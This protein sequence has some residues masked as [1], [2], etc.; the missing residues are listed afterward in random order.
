M[1]ITEMALLRRIRRRVPRVTGS[2]LLAG[3]GDDCA[4]FRAP[5]GE[6]LLYTTDLLI[7]RVHFRRESLPARLV[8][9][10]ALARGLSDVAAMGGQP[11][12][13][14]VSLALPMWADTRWVDSFYRGLAALAKETKTAVAGGDLSSAEQF[15][16]DIVV[17][18]SVPRGTAM[19]RDGARGGDGIYVSG[20]LGGAALGL[21][22]GSG[23]AWQR[24]ARPEPRLRLGT[25]LRKQGWVT[26][27]MDLSDGLSLDLFRIC[28]A[29]GVAAVV[30]R[31][32]PVFPGATLEDALH[33]GEDYELV[34]TARAGARVRRSF[35][36]IPL[37]RIGAV[38]ESSTPRVEF[39]GRR[40]KPD[41]WD[42]FRGARPLRVSPPATGRKRPSPMG[43]SPD[44]GDPADE[45]A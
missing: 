40:L 2:G 44:A 42:H 23:A 1:T 17:G 27:A 43:S 18:G 25:H 3:I 37:T 6:D 24:H 4:V 36:G 11:R 13:C 15:V 39:F 41:G 21:R 30:D 34:F 14:L 26:S 19:L 20:A 28:E 7:E 5:V 38:V 45:E 31:P 10:K 16:C 33:G 12:F 22:K 9:R 29:S 35:E 32:L 8:G